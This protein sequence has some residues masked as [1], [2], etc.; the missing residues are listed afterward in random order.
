MKNL[1]LPANSFE[2]RNDT[3]GSAMDRLSLRLMHVNL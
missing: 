2:V 3:S 1:C